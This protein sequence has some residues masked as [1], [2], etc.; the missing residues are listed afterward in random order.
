[1]WAIDHEI[2]VGANPARKI[3]L[4][5][6]HSRDRFLKAEEVPKFLQELSV[7]PNRDL[8]DFIWISL[9]SGARRG[10]VLSARWDDI[11]FD[12]H[13]W[14]IPDPKARVPYIVPLMPEAIEVL[15]LREAVPKDSPWVFPG[16]GRTG[17][18]AGLKR[19]WQV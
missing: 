18:L 15:K 4:F 13:S 7:E 3:A 9:M 17:H 1:N 16:T 2:W 8:R 5:P 10:D 11:S 12:T 6:E 19:P 14:R